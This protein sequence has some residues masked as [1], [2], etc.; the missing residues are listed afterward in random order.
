[1][2]NT[3]FVFGDF[4]FSAPFGPPPLESFSNGYQPDVTHSDLGAAPSPLILPTSPAEVG[5]EQGRLKRKTRENHPRLDLSAILQSPEAPL[6]TTPT[7]ELPRSKPKYHRT[8][9]N[10]HRIDVEA[11]LN[12][13]QSPE[14]L[15]L[16]PLP[17]ATKPSD[18]P[19]KVLPQIPTPQDEAAPSA[20]SQSFWP[21][22]APGVR[23]AVEAPKQSPQP[24]PN[25]SPKPNEDRKTILQIA[26][27]TPLELKNV[28]PDFF[29]DIEIFREAIR[30][31]YEALEYAPKALLNKKDYMILAVRENGN[32][33][34]FAGEQCAQ[35][36]QIVLEAIRQN[37]SS[38][39][40]AAKKLLRSPEFLL[41]AVE[42]DPG[43]VWYSD[44][45]KENEEFLLKAIRRNPKALL[46][47]A[48]SLREN[49]PLL[50]KAVQEDFRVFEFAG[51]HARTNVDFVISLLKNFPKVFF[52]ID[53][54]LRKS[55][56]FLLR[57]MTESPVVIFCMDE[58]LKNNKTLQKEIVE[59]DG[60]AL[61]Y[62][63][64][65][66]QRDPDI[67]LAA[68]RQN[69]AAFAFAK[70]TARTDS[71]VLEAL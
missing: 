28:N 40:F 14:G 29:F 61:Q 67:V 63:N 18:S 53:A 54:T 31:N 44:V 68:V 57:A 48:T 30:K 66:W 55:S 45:L 49:L 71:L 35:N 65:H 56:E 69:K 19:S 70:G 60:M 6:Q 13:P 43:T 27:S 4:D 11:I 20:P 12:P 50:R 38:I 21:C 9:K 42:I 36:Q 64:I 17:E 24:T 16:P 5:P 26:K 59:Q 41:K 34:R 62:L 22:M 33:L 15:L 32:C 10:P 1:M 51:P 39:R 37:F 47:A 25:I 52:F 23:K 46:Y 2:I 8:V 7:A 58:S 3:S